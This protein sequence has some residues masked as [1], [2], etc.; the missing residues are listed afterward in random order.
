MCYVHIETGAGQ[1]IT[2]LIIGGMRKIFFEVRAIYPIALFAISC[3]LILRH[4]GGQNIIEFYLWLSNYL[5][6]LPRR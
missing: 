1:T 3:S 6:I 5:N 4:T 2:D